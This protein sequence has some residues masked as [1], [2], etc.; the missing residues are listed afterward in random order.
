M[1]FNVTTWQRFALYRIM[2]NIEGNLIRIRKAHKCL[3]ALE[4]SDAD[5]EQVNWRELPG[6]L[7]AWDNDEHEWTLEI[8]DREAVKLLK[9]TVKAHQNWPAARYDD[10][11]AIYE[12]LKLEI[13]EE[14]SEDADD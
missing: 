10:V 9:E 8:G 5:K 3:D 1:K 6:G 14:E 7:V 11:L 12:A 4:M 2:G 13:P